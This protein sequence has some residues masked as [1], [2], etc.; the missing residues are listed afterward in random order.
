MYLVKASHQALGLLNNSSLDP[1]LDHAFDVLLLVLLR[2]RDV[3]AT[4]LQLS[5]CDL[6]TQHKHTHR[7]M[8]NKP[9]LPTKR[10]EVSSTPT[11]L[12]EHLLVHGEGEVQHV[13]NVVV[14]HPLQALVEFLIQVL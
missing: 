3:S 14:L 4:R 5:L 7:F 1:P 6:E 10:L 8:T 13:L 9:V 2:N 11:D 12:T